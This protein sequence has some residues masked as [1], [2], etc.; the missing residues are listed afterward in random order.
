MHN[1]IQLINISTSSARNMNLHHLHLTVQPG[2]IHYLIGLH[3]S[4]K[5]AFHEFLCGH[6]PADDG[7]FLLDG[8]HITEYSPKTAREKGIFY[9]GEGYRFLADN[10]PIYE[11]LEL[12]R[13]AAVKREKPSL[14]LKEDAFHLVQEL[15]T[16]YHI[17][18]SC[19]LHFN[20]LPKDDQYLLFLIEAAML[21]A[22]L[23]I[24]DAAALKVSVAKMKQLLQ[25][26]QMLTTSGTA[27]IFIC[28]AVTQFSD[29]PGI[30]SIM[31]NG[32]IMKQ[33]ASSESDV[34][35]IR[36]LL[37]LQQNGSPAPSPITAVSENSQQITS[38]VTWGILEEYFEPYNLQAYIQGLAEH[39]SLDN[40]NTK[41]M[42][43]LTAR[44]LL[45]VC[46]NLSI[47]DNMAMIRYPKITGRLG[48]VSRSV[49]NYLENELA[50]VCNRVGA[51]LPERAEYLPQI[52]KTILHIE[53]YVIA[54]CR[55]IMI[56]DPLI[57]LDSAGQLIFQA[58]LQDLRNRDV[59]LILLFYNRSEIFSACTNT[60]LCS[61]GKKK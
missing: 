47:G 48:Y 26:L 53:R 14:Y 33:I 12:L 57:G 45:T 35:Q 16:R 37:L 5:T 17:D 56:E 42:V 2:E 8:K 31:R 51:F 36:S 3:G 28:S 60:I 59:N 34:Q 21:N 6:L 30:I 41:D 27:V 25:L 13:Y 15:F 55:N 22:R 39:G 40:L 61:H 50:K 9:F 46:E 44:T 29:L 7:I 4:G 10:Q 49:L 23:L 43:F 32:R 20:M 54:G 1:L 11:S 52:T 24:I 19:S 58:Y 38:A 18:F